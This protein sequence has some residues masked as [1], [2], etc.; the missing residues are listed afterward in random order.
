LD[1][2]HAASTSFVLFK[3]D[4]PLQRKHVRRVGHESFVMQSQGTDADLH[5]DS[6]IRNGEIRER[7]FQIGPSEIRNLAG[8]KC[9]CGYAT[10]DSGNADA[11]PPRAKGGSTTS[12][13]ANSA[14]KFRR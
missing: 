6:K 8:A 12:T 14:G 7:P 1:V 9:N 5:D 2:S 4:R 10:S 11:K 13:I 3:A